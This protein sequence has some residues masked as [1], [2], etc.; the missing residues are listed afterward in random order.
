MFQKPCVGIRQV[1]K[2]Q[3]EEE[4]VDLAKRLREVVWGAKASVYN[5]EAGRVVGRVG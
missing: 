3:G 2:E 4:Q 1:D 5:C